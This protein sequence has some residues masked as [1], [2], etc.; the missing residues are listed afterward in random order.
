MLLAVSR[1]KPA[2]G[3]LPTL[4]SPSIQMFRVPFVDPCHDRSFQMPASPPCIMLFLF[5]LLY[6]ATDFSSFKL[7]LPFRF[8]SFCRFGTSEGTFLSR[9]LTVRFSVH[10]NMRSSLLAG[11][12]FALN[13]GQ[14]LAQVAWGGVNI[15]G[16]DFGCETTVSCEDYH[17]HSRGLAKMF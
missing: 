9:L 7:L 4:L 6:I 16:F 3:S 10:S 1:W 15:A 8:H 2:Y 12:A 5:K 14:A 13:W 11:A 17:Y